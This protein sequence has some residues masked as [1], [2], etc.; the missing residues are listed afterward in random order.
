MK[1]KDL[2]EEKARQDFEDSL[3]EKCGRCGKWDIVDEY[4][5]CDRCSEDKDDF[6]FRRHDNDPIL[7]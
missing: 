4:G 7:A 6:D 2:I 1:R 5:F 3:K